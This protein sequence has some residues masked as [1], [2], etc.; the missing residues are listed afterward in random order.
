VPTLVPK[1]SLRDPKL[2]HLGLPQLQWVA[3]GFGLGIAWVNKTLELET[4]SSSHCSHHDLFRLGQL[5]LMIVCVL[6]AAGIHFLERQQTLWH[7]ARL[8]EE[9]YYGA[10]LLRER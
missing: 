5:S 2:L 4:L 7:A 8:L 9:P 1:G 6:V 10:P 3:Y